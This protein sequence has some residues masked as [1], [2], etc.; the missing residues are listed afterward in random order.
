MYFSR[1]KETNILRGDRKHLKLRSGNLDTGLPVEEL[2]STE[3]GFWG[4]AVKSNKWSGQRKMRLTQTILERM[5]NIILK[6]HGHAVRMEDN[7]WPNWMTWL[8]GTKTTTTTRNKEGKESGKGDEAE[9][10]NIWRHN[11]PEY[12]TKGDWETVTCEPLGNR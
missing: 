9:E 12:M 8:S 5:R 7:R 6:W 2:L 10:C 4:R 3:K 11:G 1:D